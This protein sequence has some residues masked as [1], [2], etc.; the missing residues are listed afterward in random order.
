MIY[1]PLPARRDWTEAIKAVS[2]ELD[3]KQRS[4]I[5]KAEVKDDSASS[6]LSG[7]SSAKVPSLHT[8][9][10]PRESDAPPPSLSPLQTMDDFEILKVLGKG[11]FG[12]VRVH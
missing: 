4:Q 6:M 8:H 9:L 3:K 2:S 11:T 5:S 1:A 10:S 12:K 7:A